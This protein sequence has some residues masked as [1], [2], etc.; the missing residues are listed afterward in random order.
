MEAICLRRSCHLPSAATN[1]RSDSSGAPTHRVQSKCNYGLVWKEAGKRQQIGIQKTQ[2]MHGMY[3]SLRDRECNLREKDA[4]RL[5][6]KA[7]FPP[8][9]SPY[10]PTPIWDR[11]GKEG[12][13]QPARSH[14]STNGSIQPTRETASPTQSRT[15][16][17]QG[18]RLR[19]QAKPQCCTARR[20]EKQLTG[21]GESRDATCGM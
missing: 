10:P 2:S 17:S 9:K 16:S 8:P 19:G 4:L 20:K 3:N 1:V 5:S 7:I 18:V 11:L 15:L 12:V 13:S 6:P 21:M 14:T